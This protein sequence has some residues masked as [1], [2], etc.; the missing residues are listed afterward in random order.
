ME[1][2]VS[3]ASILKNSRRAVGVEVNL[4]NLWKVHFPEF[5]ESYFKGKRY[6]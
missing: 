5:S 4:I 3:M 1:V 6:N 2:V